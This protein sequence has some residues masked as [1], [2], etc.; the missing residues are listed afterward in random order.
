MLHIRRFQNFGWQDVDILA[1]KDGGPYKDVTRQ[2]LFPGQAALPAEW[3]YF[4]VAPG[5]HSTL[6]RHAHLHNVM[7]LRGRGRCLVGEDV[8][9][10]RQHDLI[11]VPTLTW[12][13]FHASPDEALGFL[14]LVHQTRDKPQLPTPDELAEIRRNHRVAEFIRP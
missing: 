7:I 12:H 13:Q 3:R 2:V 6:E 9:D 11:H 1:Y 8:A 5:G 14:C 10:I 4:E